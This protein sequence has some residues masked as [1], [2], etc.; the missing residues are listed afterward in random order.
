L[1]PR[2]QEKKKEEARERHLNQKQYASGKKVDLV[3]EEKKKSGRCKK[4]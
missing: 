3:P 1:N 4:T 2:T